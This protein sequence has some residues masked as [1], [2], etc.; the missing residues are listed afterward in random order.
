MK[1]AI[2]V[3]TTFPASGRQAESG[4]PNRSTHFNDWRLAI[5][6][7]ARLTAITAPKLLEN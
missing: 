2:T 7:H 3:G 5:N 1:T 4:M 6:H